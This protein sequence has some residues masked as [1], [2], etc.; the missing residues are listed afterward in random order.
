MG[1][2]ADVT[3]LCC[4]WVSHGSRMAS[5]AP[6][7][8]FACTH[9]FGSALVRPRKGVRT[10]PDMPAP[11]QGVRAAVAYLHSQG[12]VLSNLMFFLD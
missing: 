9:G 5:E 6:A 10:A 8:S 12:T 1:G 7:G 11:T 2:R 4:Q 3:L